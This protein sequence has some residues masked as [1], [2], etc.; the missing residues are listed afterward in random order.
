MS[1]SCIHVYIGPIVQG[2]HLTIERLGDHSVDSIELGT[3]S[4]RPSSR[5]GRIEPNNIHLVETH[6][7]HTLGDDVFSIQF[8]GCIVPR[9]I[10]FIAFRNDDAATLGE[11]KV[12]AKPCTGQYL[13]MDESTAPPPE[14]VSG[15]VLMTHIKGHRSI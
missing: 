10:V 5:R 4:W 14:E 1:T 6:T 13:V 11:D 3:Q 15:L 9:V 2:G 8:V 12:W 7:S